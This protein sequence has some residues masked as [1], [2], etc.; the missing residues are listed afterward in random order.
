MEDEYTRKGS[1]VTPKIAGTESTATITSLS[2]ITTILDATAVHETLTELHECVLR[3]IV[4]VSFVVAG[5]EDLVRGEYQHP[6][7][8]E[9]QLAGTSQAP[10]RPGG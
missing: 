10:R 2:S 4:F 3:D 9:E 1:H 6:G 5:E 7:E 8:Q